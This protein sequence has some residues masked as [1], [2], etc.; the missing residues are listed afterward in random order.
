MQTNV[1]SLRF[2]FFLPMPCFVIHC[3]PFSLF[4]IC[5]PFIPF[6]KFLTINYYITR[7]PYHL[8]DMVDIITGLIVLFVYFLFPVPHN[9]V[10]E[11][12]FVPPVTNPW[13]YGS[14]GLA[15]TMQSNCVGTVSV[16]VPM[17][18]DCDECR[19]NTLRGLLQRRSMRS[20]KKL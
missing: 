18:F 12:I 11:P 15:V 13:Q 8:H 17:Q 19:N 1:F 9:L 5:F 4:L 3:V 2:C 14:A 16:R 20:Y 7:S 10:P 6:S